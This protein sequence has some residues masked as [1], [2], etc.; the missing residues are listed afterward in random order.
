VLNLTGLLAGKDNSSSLSSLG[1]GLL[2]LNVN[3]LLADSS[4]Q[5]GG[6]LNPELNLG[7]LCV[8]AQV[9]T[10]GN[11]ANLCVQQNGT[12]CCSPGKLLILSSRN[13]LEGC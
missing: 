5:G 8:G 6:L 12:C 10:A 13:S 3:A 9:V 2:N 1:L 7:D 4:C 11:I